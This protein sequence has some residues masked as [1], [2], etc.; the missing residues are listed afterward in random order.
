MSLPTSPRSVSDSQQATRPAARPSVPPAKLLS[1]ASRLL[2]GGLRLEPSSDWLWAALGDA[3]AEEGPREFAWSRA[4]QLNPKRAGVWASL[5]RLYAR[6]GE[7]GGHLIMCWVLQHLRT[8]N[9]AWFTSCSYRARTH[10]KLDCHLA[11][12]HPIQT[13]ILVNGSM[14]VY[15]S[16]SV[17][18][19]ISVVP[20]SCQ[21]LAG[22]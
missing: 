8:M 21:C 20:S 7:G 1:Q 19:G 6:H 17:Y 12:A 9:A 3:E 10:G 15:C 4:L 14:F 16:M 22:V 11:L 5:G 2:R 18:F 13:L